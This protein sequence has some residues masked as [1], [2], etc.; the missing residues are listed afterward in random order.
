MVNYQSMQPGVFTEF[1]QLKSVNTNNTAHA[2][3][4]YQNRNP[5][6]NYYER[7]HLNPYQDFMYKR[8][9]FGLSAYSDKR[10]GAMSYT[11]KRKVRKYQ[12]KTQR[13]LNIWKQ[14]LTN[15]L[16]DQLTKINFP[17][18]KTNPFVTIFE[19]TKIGTS[20]GK[21]TDES[22]TNTLSFKTL[23]IKKPRII[24]KLIQEKILPENFYNLSRPI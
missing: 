17:K 20:F 11:D 14:Q 5:R 23:N 8:A 12:E 22:F 24:Q 21:T 3:N 19:S 1:S 13:I 9:L 10:V 7:S 18:F 6:Q 2:E 16:F 15:Q 4:L